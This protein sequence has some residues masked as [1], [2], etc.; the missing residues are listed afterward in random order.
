MST[1]VEVVGIPAGGWTELGRAAQLIIERADVLLGGARHLELVPAGREQHRIA[2][3]RRL[4]EE[5][6]GLLAAHDGARVV[7]LASGDPLVAGVGAT[8]VELLGAELV[9]IHPAVSSVGLARARLGWDAE[10][11]DTV[12][13]ASAEA[14]EVKALLSPGRRVVAL[15]RD[16]QSPAMIMQALVAAGFGPSRVIIFG[17]LGTAHESRREQ[18]AADGVTGEVPA[19]NLVCVEC[20]PDRV[21]LLWS[22]VPGLPDDAYEHDGQLSKRIVRAAALAHLRPAPGE[23]LWDLGAGAGSV[24]IEWCRAAARATAIAVERDPDRSARIGRNAAA[25]GV[26]QLQVVTGVTTESLTWLPA[27]D[28]VFVGGGASDE[29]VRV[30]RAMLRP[31][32]RLVVHAVTVET[33]TLLLGL[34]DRLG[35]QLTRIAVEDLEPIGRYHGWKP[36][37]AVTQWSLQIPLLD[38]DLEQEPT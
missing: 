36:A 8:L 2:W 11:V 15:S 1:P 21:G 16:A 33:E 12:R 5:L 28:A 9:R 29:L 32:G 19:L 18:S 38:G 23:L 13:I 4:R 7:V 17:D 37:R 14:V 35:G 30:A 34:H 22:S 20:V 25:L 26:T 31:G 24:A 6:P 3:P 27:P 10:T